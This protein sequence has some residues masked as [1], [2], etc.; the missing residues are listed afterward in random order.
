MSKQVGIIESKGTGAQ[1]AEIF[2]KI[3]K[4]IAGDVDFYSF[5][6]KYNY[7]PHTFNSISKDF[8][9]EPYSKLKKTLNKEVHDIEKFYKDCEKSCHGIFRSAI[10]AETLYYLRKNLKKIKLVQ[11]HINYLGKSK[12]IFFVRDQ[13]QGFYSNIDLQIKTNNINGSYNYQLSNFNLIA[14]FVKNIIK[15]NNLLDYDLTYLY[16]FHLFGL[17]LKK[18]ILKSLKKEKIVINDVN[19]NIMQPD[20]ALNNLLGNLFLKFKSNNL[21]I[22]TGNEIGDFLLE[23]LIHKYNLGSK[24][25]FYT[26]NYCFI[27]NDTPLEILQTMHGSADDIK[28]KNILNPIATIKAASYALENWLNIDNAINKTNIIIKRALKNKIVTQDL[29][30]TKSTNEVVDYFLSQWK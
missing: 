27:H 18:M 15:N 30:G 4:A 28:D 14:K 11:L 22:V 12:K 13:I 2:K 16:K 23:A 1:V 24:D 19:F 25:T 6:S 17:E 5:Y 8:A 10:N 7:Y 20:T 9:N 3:I 29:H 21:I 26:K